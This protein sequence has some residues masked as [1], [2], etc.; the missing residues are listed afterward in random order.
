MKTKEL[1][2]I[3]DFEAL[4]PG[5]LLVCEFKRNMY[6]KPT[7]KGVRFKAFEIALNRA[8][9]KEIIL[10]RKMNLYFNYKMFVDKDMGSN[11]IS[12]TLI[13]PSEPK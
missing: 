13:T 2:T 1:L 6:L 9:T 12:A 7:C 5:D 10:Q 4:N 11:L 8:D 3:E